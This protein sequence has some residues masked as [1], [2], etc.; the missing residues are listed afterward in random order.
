MVK[1]EIV[2]S[3]P[4]GY[5]L[6]RKRN[7]AGG[8]TYYSDEVPPSVMIWDTSLID[9]STLLFAIAHFLKEWGKDS[10]NVEELKK[11]LDKNEGKHD[12]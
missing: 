10:K 7:S 11:L 5:K 6:Y 8:W 3:L 12:G 2:D 1:M 4:S 9:V